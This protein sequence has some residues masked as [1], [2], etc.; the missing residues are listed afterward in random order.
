MYFKTE[1][2]MRIDARE[3]KKVASP[4]QF[5][6]QMEFTKNSNL[7]VRPSPEPVIVEETP[8]KAK[9][10][11][12]FQIGVDLK[13]LSPNHSVSFEHHCQNLR[14][15]PRK[16]IHIKL[17]VIDTKQVKSNH[18]MKSSGPPIQQNP[19]HLFIDSRTE[20]SPNKIEGRG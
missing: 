12:G 5:Y 10:K 3:F 9:F 16:Q 2:D 18:K 17:P 4:V 1:F 11:V 20:T 6:S 13:A 19:S 7:E 14:K 15:R 8:P